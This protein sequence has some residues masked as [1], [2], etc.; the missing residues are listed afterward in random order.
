M[1]RIDGTTSRRALRPA[2]GVR[3]LL[4]ALTP[5]LGTPQDAPAAVDDPR[6]PGTRAMA[7]RLAERTAQIAARGSP[8]M[9]KRQLERIEAALATA[10]KERRGLLE[11]QRAQALLQVG[12]TE[13][14]VK[15]FEQLKKVIAQQKANPR[16][17]ELLEET[18]S[19]LAIAWLRLGEQENCLARHGP[20][21]CI[22]PFSSAAR[23]Q[24]VRG[25]ENAFD[26]LNQIL[27]QRPDDPGAHWLLNLAAMALGRWPDGLAAE[28]RIPPA[29]FASDVEFPRFRDVAQAAG[30]S[31]D[32]LA[33]GAVADDFDGDGWID[34]MASSW[35]YYDPLRVWRN[36]GDGTFEE[37]TRDAGLDG[38]HGGLNLVSGDFD[39]DGRVD[40]FVPRGG[41]MRD[42]GEL[43]NSLLLNR[44]GFRFDDVTIA[45]GM[46]SEKPTQTAAA[47]DFDLDGWLDL[48]VAYETMPGG[49]NYPCELWQNQRDGT[50]RDV[51]A[52]A[53]VAFTQFV[54]GVTATDADGDGRPDLFLSVINA[55]NRLL[56]N[57]PP[58]GKRAAPLVFADASARAGISGPL[59]SFP[60][61]SFDFDNDGD[62][63]LLCASYVDLAKRQ[64]NDVGRM[65]LGLPLEAEPTALYRNRG[66]GT[67]E[68]IGR[69][70]GLADVILTMGCNFGDL[71]NDGWLDAVF[72]TGDPD[73]R[74]LLPN[75]AL[76]ND[77]GRRFL[78]VTTNGGFGHLQKGHGVAFA[79]F[80]NDGDQD[81]FEVLGG[82]FEG[83]LFRRILM[84][85]P[86]NANGWLT[87]ELVGRGGG[88]SGGGGSNRGAIGTRVHVR[89]TTP[90]GP[91]SIRVT[92][93][94]GGSFGASSLQQ[95]IGLG[96]ASAI[97]FVEVFWPA[98]GK[99]QKFAGVA[100][101]QKLR[102]VEGATAPEPVALRRPAPAEGADHGADSRR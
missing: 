71:D 38:L 48:F 98:S 34:V 44:G 3:A 73:F 92:G 74:T 102:I 86:G 37:R 18:E 72:G 51:A 69:E 22:A 11:H 45:A 83:D 56:R 88:P 49:A 33:G 80:D 96:D 95:E 20:E 100:M 23:H 6:T 90:S 9:N 58:D 17:A 42:S 14:A 62:D 26:L 32:G 50:F 70:A 97:E 77:G 29:A 79:D 13:E 76:K 4:L 53:G 66:D 7:A 16:A 59:L 31:V 19:L 61:W 8:F 39:N 46:R 60:C 85:N 25:A 63:D 84:E 24:V 67:Y 64:A 94:S 2:E 89:V 78:D 93:G 1:H 68:E 81:V 47:A 87:I 55:P 65:L 41:W 82:A 12:R 91:R 54:K 5:P 36:L 30:L 57:L 28:R 43:P 101:N 10:P 75:R 21:S 52:A 27:D 35:G 99:R 40:V 15:R